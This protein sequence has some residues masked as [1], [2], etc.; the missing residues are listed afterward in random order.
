M[1]FNETSRPDMRP[2][3]PG[4]EEQI[5]SQFTKKHAALQSSALNRRSVGPVGVPLRSTSSRNVPELLDS[6]VP[7]HRAL[8]NADNFIS[9]YNADGS[10]GEMTSNSYADSNNHSGEL[11][12][13]ED[14]QLSLGSDDNVSHPI[15]MAHGM[16]FDPT[17]KKH[18]E[19]WADKG[20]AKIVR[21]VTNPKTGQTT[22]EVIRK[23]IKDFKF[24]DTLGDGSYSTVMVATSKENGKK[25]A[26]KILSKEYLIRQKKVKYVNIEKNALQR[27]NNSRGIIKLYFTFQDESSLYFLLEYAPNGD[28][29]SV[30][31]KFGS[32][33]EECA[34]Y[35]SA[36]IIDAINFL[37]IKG[38]IHRDIK[39]ENIL[40]DKEMKVKLTD[41]GTAKILEPK[42]QSH[43]SGSSYD[44][45]TRSKSFVGTA[46]YVSPELLNDNWVDYRCDIWAF[47]CILFQ[48]IAGKPPFKATNE[49]LTFQ[50][51]M[52]VQ[53]AFTAGF[54][55]VIRDLVKRTLVKQPD[56]RLTIP[57]I[58]RHHFFKDKNFKDG[59]VWEEPA[60]E[61]QPYRM[62]AKSM[63][64]VPALSTN[65]HPL[66]RPWNV[67]PNSSKISVNTNTDNA[68][69]TPSGSNATSPLAATPGNHSQSKP[70][71][72]VIVQ[73]KVMDE[74]TA[75]IL[76]NAKRAVDSRK[77]SSHRKYSASASALAPTG[78]KN[79]G[80]PETPSSVSSASLAPSVPHVRSKS[81]ATTKNTGS[82][83]SPMISPSNNSSSNTVDSARRS[84]ESPLLSPVT[85]AQPWSRPVGDESSSVDPHDTAWDY[86]LTNPDEHVL[87][88]GELNFAI[89]DNSS[90]ERRVHKSRGS[91]TESQR[92]G[93]SRAT[94][95]SQV[96][97]GGGGVTG[98][99]SD[100]D[101]PLLEPDF[102][103]KCHISKDDLAPEYRLPGGDPS[104]SPPEE[105]ERSPN[106][107]EDN[108]NSPI[109]GKFKRFFYHGGKQESGNDV[110]DI[111]SYHRRMLVVTSFGR[112]LV[113]ARKKRNISNSSTNYDLCYDINI[114][115]SGIK[116]REVNV[117]SITGKSGNFVIQTPFDSF[118]FRTTKTSSEN[119]LLT[120]HESI[121][122]NHERLV[123]NS[124]KED[125]RHKSS[126][127]D[128]MKAAKLATPTVVKER[129]THYTPK[130]SKPLSPQLNS[131]PKT[132]KTPRSSFYSLGSGGSSGSLTGSVPSGRSGKN[133]RMF[134]SFVNSKEKHGKKRASPVP[135]S[136]K[137]VNGLPFHNYSTPVGLGIP[138]HSQSSISS[139]TPAAAA[140]TVKKTIN[141]GNSRLLARSEQ[142]FR[143]KH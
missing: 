80:P 100:S 71:S 134:D 118:L 38:I 74:K 93:P 21:D 48:M 125:G 139:V 75:Q 43:G 33:S 126:S 46:E 65:H 103:K 109:S 52:K 141:P 123:S 88:A 51:V 121:R 67:R 17:L 111:G 7:M 104:L 83:G 128:A 96:A 36:Q 45:L 16:Q 124:R 34:C 95:L 10:S 54:P 76:D 133:E 99:R 105:R 127:V 63:Q 44:L 102:Y 13:G 30:M 27:L 87:E 120:L 6:D 98:L 91:L 58:E 101:A 114:C 107:S 64:P 28:F 5:N 89:L 18:R 113:F 49:Y 97:R 57:Q 78:K 143:R 82:Y 62:T 59:S 29:L 130:S 70:S 26:V 77:G 40:L 53:Y 122:V 50:K 35:Y 106:L 72:P 129:E 32:L 42:Q 68:S 115:Q 66:K 8:T 73:K 84:S 61:I 110:I 138:S 47:G 90:L 56:Q 19:E 15:E 12:A 117:P 14:D 131:H 116:L 137:L 31:K 85:A 2:L 112:A 25:Y 132:P 3:L 119:W 81:S 79:Y 140:K 94:L 4:D 55:L 86:H 136:S 23:G 39:P 135:I 9:M 22:R 60:P 108:P 24:G 92:H 20:A 1:P 69:S 142:T 11:G 37:H 41:F